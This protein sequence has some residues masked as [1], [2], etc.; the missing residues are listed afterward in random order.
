MSQLTRRESGGFGI[1]QT[2]TLDEIQDLVAGEMMNRYIYP[3][4]YAVKGWPIMR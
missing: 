3:V 4:D 1:D 2:V